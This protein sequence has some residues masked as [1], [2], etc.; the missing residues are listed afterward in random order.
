MVD[1]KLWD[2]YDIAA[3]QDGYL[4]IP[5]V[6]AF[7]CLIIQVVAPICLAIRAFYADEG[8]DLNIIVYI[9]RLFFGVYAVLYELKLQDESGEKERLK[10]VPQ[11]AT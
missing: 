10:F 5:S 9:A 6:T 2:I 3:A 4:N 11:Y 1:G 7:F 8:N